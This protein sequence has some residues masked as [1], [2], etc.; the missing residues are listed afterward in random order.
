MEATNAAAA[1]SRKLFD[2]VKQNRLDPAAIL[3]SRR[4]DIEAIASINAALLGGLQSLVRQ[5]AAF[6][7][8]TAAELQSLARRDQGAEGQAVKVSEVLPRSL[9]KAVDGLRNVT[10]TVYKVQADSIATVGKRLAENV[11]EAKGILRP[12]Q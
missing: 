10:D 6:L 8:D 2:F 5:Q 7:T 4:K 9:Q 3:E 12:R 11:E 1:A